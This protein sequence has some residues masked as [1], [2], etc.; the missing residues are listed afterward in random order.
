VWV[1][2][3]V[4]FYCLAIAMEGFF[5]APLS[6]LER[7]LFLGAAIGFFFQVWWVKAAGVAMLVIAVALQTKFRKTPQLV[8]TLKGGD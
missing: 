7:A 4:G 2:A 6:W 5:R 1:T 8:T 3:F